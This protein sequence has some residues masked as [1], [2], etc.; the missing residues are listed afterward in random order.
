M[1]RIKIFEKSPMSPTIT[2]HAVAFSTEIV[3]RIG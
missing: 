2:F 3:K 1:E